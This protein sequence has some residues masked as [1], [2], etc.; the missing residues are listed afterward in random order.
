MI[1]WY[2]N[3][4]DVLN[5][6][7]IIRKKRRNIISNHLVYVTHLLVIFVIYW[8]ILLKA[9]HI[10]MTQRRQLEK[11]IWMFFKTTWF[12]TRHF[13]RLLLFNTCTTT[14]LMYHSWNHTATLMASRKFFLPESKNS[15]LKHLEQNYWNKILQKWNCGILTY[16]L[17]DETANKPAIVVSTYTKKK[18]VKV[19]NKRRKVTTKP[20]MIHEDN[21]S[22]NKCDRGDRMVFIL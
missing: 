2:K 21:N 13:C 19:T 5:T 4:R 10:V 1:I 11:N 22:I 16:M 6:K 12:R 9:H 3:G 14:L 17:R 7:C 20:R 15:K 8:F 18:E